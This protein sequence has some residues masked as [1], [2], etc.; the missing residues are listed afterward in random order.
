MAEEVGFE[1]TERVQ[2][3]QTISSRSRYDH[4]DTP[5]YS[6]FDVLSEKGENYT[7]ELVIFRKRALRFL[8][9]TT[10][11]FSGQPSS[12]AMAFRVFLVSNIYGKPF[13]PRTRSGNEKPRQRLGFSGAY[14]FD[15]PFW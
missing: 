4:F 9:V 13:V 15:A 5:P 10:G 12:K 2:A 14:F 7:R 6:V 8:P 3:A 1:P 11:I